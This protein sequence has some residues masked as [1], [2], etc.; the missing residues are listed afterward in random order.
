[1]G[2]FERVGYKRECSPFFLRLSPV[3]S[4]DCSLFLAE[5]QPSLDSAKEGLLAV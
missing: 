5:V 1:V 4:S 2:K 3:P